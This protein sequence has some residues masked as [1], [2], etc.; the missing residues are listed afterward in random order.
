M[1]KLNLISII[2]CENVGKSQLFNKIVGK[3]RSIV[4]SI[5]NTTVDAIFENIK[6]GDTNFTIVDTPAYTEK[7]SLENTVIESINKNI[8]YIID[9]SNIVLFVVTDDKLVTQETYDLFKRLK[10]SSKEI[11]LIINKKNNDKYYCLNDYIKFGF[12][13]YIEISEKSD[14]DIKKIKKIILKETG[15]INDIDCNYYDIDKSNFAISIIGRPNVGKS[16]LANAFSENIKIIISE[17]PGTTRDSVYFPINVNKND[18]FLIDTAGIRKKTNIHTDVE[19]SAIT[20]AFNSLKKSDVVLLMT[21]IE[22]PILR[23]DLKLL[24]FILKKNKPIVLLVNKCDKLSKD[25]IKEKKRDIEDKLLFI[26]DFIDI[27]YISAINKIGIKKIF[28]SIEKIRKIFNKKFSTS[29]LTSILYK[30]T[31]ENIPPSNKGKQ[32]KLK[33]AHFGC[34]FPLKII[35]HGN[36]YLRNLQESYIKY[37]KKQF[38]KELEIKGS[39]LEIEFK[40]NKN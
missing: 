36:S 7:R 18:Y 1:N 21:D 20:K 37:L 13:N 23:Q 25:K 30:A 29:K 2:G 14:S 24:S 22:Q 15:L 26:K 8:N 17:I 19:K 12:N 33:Y 35:I 4:S 3:D 34:N 27:I 10:K 32:P 38:T 11:I 16:T 31:S 28:N 6:I 39:V 40:Y 9:I 5:K